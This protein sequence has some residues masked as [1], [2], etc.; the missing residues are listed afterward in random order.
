MSHRLEEVV[1]STPIKFILS[2]KAIEDLDQL[3]SDLLT[4]E[5]KVALK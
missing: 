5:F 1:S 3:E 4:P 2:I